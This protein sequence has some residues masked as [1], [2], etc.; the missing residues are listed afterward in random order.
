MSQE[1]RLR[2]VSWNVH[3]VPGAPRIEERLESIAKVLASRRA[4]LV[5]LQEVWRARDAD[6]L[7]ELLAPAGFASVEVPGGRRIPL[8]NPPSG[9]G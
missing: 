2:L 5:L 4:D 8:R 6:R 1:L 7:H 3:G 9:G